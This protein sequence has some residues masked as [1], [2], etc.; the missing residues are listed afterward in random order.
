MIALCQ[1]VSV[2]VLAT[3]TALQVLD[4]PLG[5]EVVAQR[6]VEV[7]YDLLASPV[8]VMALTIAKVETSEVGQ[9]PLWPVIVI[10]TFRQAVPR[11][12]QT[13]FGKNRL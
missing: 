8:N 2:I 11:Q 4:G 3:V 1:C 13:L 5:S 7:G 6:N 9:A 10:Q 12:K